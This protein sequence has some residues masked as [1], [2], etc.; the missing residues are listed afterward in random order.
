MKIRE[1]RIV[2]QSRE[3]ALRKAAEV[4]EKLRKG[5]HVA[6]S[7]TLGFPDIAVFRK[8]LTQRR[9]EMLHAIRRKKPE[10]IYELAKFL[11]RDL[12]SVNTDIALLK[13]L[14]L[15]RLEKEKRGRTRV[16]PR[17]LFDKMQISIAIA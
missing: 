13:Q 14:G 3:Q 6:P 5:E 15:I 1:V 11:N 9:I 7:R 4:F 12:K 8:F 17:V 2:I 10:S 16:I